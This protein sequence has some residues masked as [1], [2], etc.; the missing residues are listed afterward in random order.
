MAIVVEADTAA[1]VLFMM[2]LASTFTPA[3]VAVMETS[4]ASVNLASSALRKAAASNEATSPASAKRADTM[5]L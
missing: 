5:G 1:A 3:E 4:S 2:S